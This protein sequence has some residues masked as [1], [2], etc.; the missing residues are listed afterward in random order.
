LVEHDARQLGLEHESKDE[1]NAGF[2][3]RCASPYQTYFWIAPGQQVIFKRHLIEVS[4]MGQA[5]Q[6]FLNFR[7]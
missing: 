1:V 2:E 4:S 3:S 7:Y 6:K 5:R